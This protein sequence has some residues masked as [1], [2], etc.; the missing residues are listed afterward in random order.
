MNSRRLTEVAFLCP[1][2]GAFLLTP[3]TILV[4]QSLSEIIGFP[5][6]LV[7]LFAC[8]A[9][10]IVIAWRI[11]VRLSAREDGERGVAFRPP[12]KAE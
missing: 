9:G 12:T 2:V 4:V 6:F 1:W 11:S 5:L 7:Y 10:L 8:W 3:P